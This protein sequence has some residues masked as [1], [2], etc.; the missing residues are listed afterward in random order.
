MA[1]LTREDFIIYLKEGRSLTE[2]DYSNLDLRGLD[3]QDIQFD[4]SNFTGAKLTGNNLGGGQFPP[5]RPRGDRS[6]PKPC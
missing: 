1:E 3:L 2:L 4:G 5:V 6:R